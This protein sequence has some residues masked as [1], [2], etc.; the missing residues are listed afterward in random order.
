MLAF[1]DGDPVAILKSK[2]QLD[3]DACLATVRQ[4]FPGMHFDALPDSDLSDS[5]P[6]NGELYVGCFPGLTILAHDS[7]V[8]EPSALDRRFL[9]FAAGRTM[10]HHVMISTVDG[11]AYGIWEHGELRR[12][13]VI[14]ADSGTTEDIGQRR[15]FEEPFWAGEHQHEPPNPD[16]AGGAPFHPLELAEAALLALFGYQLEGIIGPD[17]VQ[18]ETV[19]MMCFA[20]AASATATSASASA[21]PWWKFW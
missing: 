13:F 15:P 16:Y 17:E 20:P 12:S 18:P 19:P 14:D 6:R 1:A 7:L 10:I 11:F 8:T 3:R 21:R 9:D 4:L 2:P 5:Y